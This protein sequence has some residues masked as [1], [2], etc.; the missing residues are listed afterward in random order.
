M[1]APT[2]AIAFIFIHRLSTENQLQ[3]QWDTNVDFFLP[4]RI[5]HAADF[6]E[7][8]CR[9]VVGIH[10]TTASVAFVKESVGL[11]IFENEVNA[12]VYGICIRTFGR[13]MPFRQKGHANECRNA[14]GFTE[15][16]GKRAIGLLHAREVIKR[17]FHGGINAV[18]PLGKHRIE[19]FLS[20]AGHG[21]QGAGS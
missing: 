2:T 14:G 4:S 11:L 13:K 9:N 6:G 21:R 5:A 10:R 7:K 20:D 18:L 19:F 17:F 1:I 15:V 8:Q 3:G 16:F 12:A